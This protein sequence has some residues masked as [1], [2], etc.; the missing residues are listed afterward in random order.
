MFTLMEHDALLR[1]MRLSTGG[2]S[3]SQSVAHWLQE[4]E[5]SDNPRAI[6]ARLSGLSDHTTRDV[7]AVA[8]A[9]RRTG[10][11][12]S[13]LGRLEYRYNMENTARAYPLPVMEYQR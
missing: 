10:A 1:L 7:Q 8:Q 12:P 13:T 2:I 9:A 11:K 5:R 4:W 6:K 3:D